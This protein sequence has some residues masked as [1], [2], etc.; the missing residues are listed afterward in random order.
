[1]SNSM[2]LIRC[3]FLV[4]IDLSVCSILENCNFTDRAKSERRNKSAKMFK[5]RA[6][7][8]GPCLMNKGIC[9]VGPMVKVILAFWFRLLDL[10][11]NFSQ[12]QLNKFQDWHTFDEKVPIIVFKISGAMKQ[13]RG[14]YSTF[15]PFN[16]NVPACTTFIEIYYW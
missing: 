6:P 10:D 4:S 5:T 7:N 13:G 15:K 1:M 9:N 14:T 2:I 11:T 3:Y 16:L 12:I 8:R